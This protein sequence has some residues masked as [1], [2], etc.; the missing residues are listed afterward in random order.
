MN[1]DIKARITTYLD[2]LENTANNA[3]AF[4]AEQVPLVIQEYL[5][6]C[7]YSSLFLTCCFGLLSLILLV[8]CRVFWKKDK[9]VE[10]GAG[11][12]VV[13][14]VWTGVAALGSAAI[15]VTHVYDLIRVIVAPRILILEYVTN[16]VS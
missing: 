14:S 3:T 8:A 15:A 16:L 4:A 9:S 5:A 13:L 6:W 12:W 2:H 10:E 11:G 7:F 1:E